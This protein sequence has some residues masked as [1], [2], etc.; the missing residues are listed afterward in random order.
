MA[1]R[2]P[3]ASRAR[4]LRRDSSDAEMRLWLAV[5]G[6]RVEG[7]KFRRQHPWGPY[8]LDFYCAEA[9]LVIEVDGGQHAEL[10]A[11]RDAIRTERLQ[12]H[13]LMVLRFWN[14]EVLQNLEGCLLKIIEVAAVRLASPEKP[15][16]Q[17]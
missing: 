17:N 12:H 2:E 16:P 14:N 6:R 8:V 4:R 1:A 11:E 3:R 9:R 5:K 13:G 10:T 7:L 15:S